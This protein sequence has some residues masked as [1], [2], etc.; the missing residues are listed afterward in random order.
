M[1]EEIIEFEKKAWDRL[2]IKLKQ[3]VGRRPDVQGILFLIGHRELGQL[4]TDFKKEEKQ[5]LIHVGVCTLLA[6]E[7]Y[8]HFIAKDGDGWPHFELNYDMPTLSGENQERLLKKLILEY[9]EDLNS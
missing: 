3:T 5:D 4:R 1:T 9:F 8:Y 7:G 2:R 6:R